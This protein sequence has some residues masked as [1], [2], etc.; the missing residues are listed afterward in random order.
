[1]K[2]TF[3]LVCIIILFLNLF[4][5]KLVA[6][7]KN[8][9][10]FVVT[11]QNDSI[12]GRLSLSTGKENIKY[13]IIE[14]TDSQKKYTFDQIKRYGYIDGACYDTRLL[15]DTI[16]RV[17][18]QGKV[19]LYKYQT[20]LYIGKE[21]EGVYRLETFTNRVVKNGEMYYVED[22]KWKGKVALLTSDCNMDPEELKELKLSEP[23]LTDFVVKYNRC[24]NTAYFEYNS[25]KKW[26]KASFG[27]V[28][29]YY[30]STLKVSND[31]TSYYYTNQTYTEKHPSIGAILKVYYPRVSERLSN[32]VEINITKTSFNS[33]KTYEFPSQDEIYTNSFDFTVL[34]IPI[35]FNYTF[36]KDQKNALELFG[37]GVVDFFLK[38]EANISKQIISGNG[39]FSS[40]EDP[41]GIKNYHA[42]LVGGIGY[43][44]K[45]SKTT[46]RIDLRYFS[47]ENSTFRPQFGLN[48]QRLAISFYIMI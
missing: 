16:L 2:S 32:Q 12:F 38:S 39:S 22:I 25:N 34:S 24:A 4:S 13:C 26:S 45:T 5:N 3:F 20:T 8:Y 6:Q 47:I 14:N 40:E 30:M 31:A 43:Q 46:L 41:Y 36:L 10:G 7:K 9:N 15:Q 44:R 37:G 21:G 17:L 1:M 29:G 18:V 19:S 35:T 48:T 42:G 11:D 23:D 27:L 33:V 28:G